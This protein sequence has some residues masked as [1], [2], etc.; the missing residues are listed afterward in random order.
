M[1][2][3]V[4]GSIGSALRI[5]P[6]DAII[7]INLVALDMFTASKELKDPISIMVTN[8][9]WV[10]DHSRARGLLST[11]LRKAKFSSSVLILPVETR[12][13]SHY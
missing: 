1:G 8:F 5:E 7:Q 13:T 9:V 2:T 6:V 3:R 12:W 10:N 11:Q 4:F